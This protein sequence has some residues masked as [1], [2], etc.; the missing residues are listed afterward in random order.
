MEAREIVQALIQHGFTQR[1]IADRTGIPQP[2]VSK[3]YRGAVSDV[4]SR[5]YRELEALH[6]SVV[7]ELA[8]RPGIEP[9]KA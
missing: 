2:T 4:L 9:A 5:N 3:V 1:Q 7:A 6:K 8:A